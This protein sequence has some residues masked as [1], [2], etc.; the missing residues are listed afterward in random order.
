MDN[1]SQLNIFLQRVMS[2][3]QLRAS[4]VSLYAVLCQM[5]IS[6]GCQSSFSISRSRIMKLARIKSTATYHKVI[7]QLIKCGYILYNPS[8]HPVKGSKV[9]LVEKNYNGSFD[10]CE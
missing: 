9:S 5:W 1:L 2:D 4:H 3:V 8:Y 10:L 7:H 6:S